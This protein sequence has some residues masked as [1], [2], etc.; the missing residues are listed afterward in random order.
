MDDTRLKAVIEAAFDSV[1]RSMQAWCRARFGHAPG[2]ACF[3]GLLSAAQWLV[4]GAINRGM[5]PHQVRYAK[6]GIEELF[7]ATFRGLENT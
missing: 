1:A 6:Q 4:H 7:L 5:R 3:T 2:R